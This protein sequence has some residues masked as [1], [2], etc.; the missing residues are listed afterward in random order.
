MM[1]DGERQEFAWKGNGKNKLE[2]ELQ[3]EVTTS[4]QFF[5]ILTN[6]PEK[7]KFHLNF[8]TKFYKIDRLMC[9]WVISRHCDNELD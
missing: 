5:Q 8:R 9:R 2:N 6:W 4:K 7:K 1:S 3:H